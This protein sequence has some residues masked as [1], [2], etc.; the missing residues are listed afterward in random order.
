[1][2]HVKTADILVVED[3]TANGRLA[4]VVLRE[5]GHAVR[6]VRSA[7]EARNE[8]RERPPDVLVLD[9]TLETDGLELL[10]ALRFSPSDPRGG[11]VVL[12]EAGDTRG[13]ELAQQLGAAAVIAKPLKGPE[14]ASAVQELA[15]WL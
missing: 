11:I 10:Q 13:R 7:R 12:S 15:T 8:L 2:K 9:L 5:E 3:D 14:L 6:W 1:M 4:A